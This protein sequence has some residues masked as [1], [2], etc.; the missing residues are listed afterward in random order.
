MA[1]SRC[2]HIGVPV[3]SVCGAMA[4]NILQT[5][6]QIHSPEL[7]RYLKFINK[8]LEFLKPLIV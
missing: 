3:K 5:A 1:G 2:L 6:W 4:K 8:H 7:F